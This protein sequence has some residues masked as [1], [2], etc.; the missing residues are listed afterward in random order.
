MLT[1]YRSIVGQLNWISQH[2]R[3][4][5]AFE[6]SFLSRSNR[7]ACGKQ[8]TKLD[9][10]VRLIQEEKRG[11]KMENICHGI[12]QLI[13]YVDASLGGSEDGKSQLGY[14]VSIEDGKM[15]RCHL[16][17]RSILAKRVAT[18]TIEAET[19]AL[20]EGIE[21]AMY[22]QHVW[23]EVMDEKLKIVIRTDSRTLSQAVTST[24][25]VLSRKLMINLASIRE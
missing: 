18:S 13:V 4:D 22:L 7:S 11:I 9:K 1:K 8:V 15:K 20:M 10:V 16:A 17:W 23:E 14:I 21:M 5:I 19:L 2:T 3:P 6:V 25:N 24:S 12:R